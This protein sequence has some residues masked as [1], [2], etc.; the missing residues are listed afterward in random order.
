MFTVKFTHQPTNN[1]FSSFFREIAGQLYTISAI[2]KL[3]PVFA[4]TTKLTLTP[5]FPF[6]HEVHVTT[7]LLLGNDVHVTADLLLGH[8][9]HIT[10]DQVTGISHIF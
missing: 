9:V 2:H 8:E 3:P 10:A 7:D 5:I 6:G 4:L 1:D